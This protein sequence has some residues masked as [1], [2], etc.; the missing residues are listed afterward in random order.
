MSQPPVAVSE[1]RWDMDAARAQH[2]DIVSTVGDTH[3]ITLNFGK[4]TSVG[5]ALTAGLRRRIV[6]P[7]LSAKHLRDALQNLLAAVDAKKAPGR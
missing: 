1:M 3:A 5:E 2:C 7:P 4:T 6:M